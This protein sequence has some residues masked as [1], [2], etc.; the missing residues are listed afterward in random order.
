MYKPQT[1]CNFNYSMYKTIK[2]KNNPRSSEDIKFQFIQESHILFDTLN[3]LCETF[4]IP[5]NIVPI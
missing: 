1:K 4:T 5:K 3:C 2:I